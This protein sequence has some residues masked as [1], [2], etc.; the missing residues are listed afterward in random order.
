MLNFP[1]TFGSRMD[2]SQLVNSYASQQEVT[3]YSPATIT[4]IQPRNNRFSSSYF[5]FKTDHRLLYWSVQRGTS[6]FGSR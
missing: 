4:S 6:F 1:F 3:R 5:V 2:F